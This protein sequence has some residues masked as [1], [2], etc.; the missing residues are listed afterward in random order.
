MAKRLLLIS[1]LVVLFTASVIQA[2]TPLAGPIRAAANKRYFVDAN[3]S[4]FFWLGDT[5]W[6]LFT[7]YTTSDVQTYLDDR[8]AKGFTV[9]Q[10]VLCWWK[11]SG[12]GC[13][14]NTANQNPFL[15]DNPATPN[16]AYFANVDAIVDAAN[17]RG[18]AVAMLPV[19]SHAFISGAATGGSTM[20]N[21]SNARAY[22]RYLGNRYKG[23]S[24]IIWLLGGD[25]PV[26]D[27]AAVYQE[28]AAGIREFDTQVK[29]I[30][31][32][33]ASTNVWPNWSI[34]ATSVQ[35]MNPYP[36]PETSLDFH[37]AESYKWLDK[38]PLLVQ[39]MYTS[40]PSKPVVLG[41][42]S[43]EG[44]WVDTSCC[45]SYPPVNSAWAVRKQAYWSYLGGGSYTYGH[46]AIWS[47]GEWP[48]ASS[49]QAALSAPGAQA[50]AVVK[51]FFTT[52]SWWQ[53]QP[54]NSIFSSGA[55]SGLW[56]NAAAVH[57]S[58]SSALVYISQAAPFTLDLTKVT[59]GIQ[60]AATWMDPRT[61]A[62]TPG[63]QYNT[64][65]QPFT[66]PAGFEDAVL[67]LEGVAG[68]GDTQPP[69]ISAIQA[70]QIAQTSAVISWRTD[71]P[72]SSIVEY[73]LSTSYNQSASAPVV[74]VSHNVPLS[75]LSAGATYHYRVKSADGA[76]N[77][78][79]SKDNVFTTQAATANSPAAI[80]NL[81]VA[82]VLRNSAKLMWSAPTGAKSYDL[83]YSTVAIT[84]STWS[85]ASQ[86]TGEPVPGTAGTNQ[87]FTLDGLAANTNYF[88]AIKSIGTS[89]NSSALSNVQSFTTKKVN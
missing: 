68:S 35:A 13:R 1:V 21:T 55:G 67:I 20:I 53:F 69:A 32:H 6:Q 31:Y 29:L 70:G 51:A 7:S 89:G 74:D 73:G 46:D 61:G 71:E 28:L 24:N 26:F 11:T 54:D 38:I 72:A 12:P 49:W 57:S 45:S 8:Q 5:P 43:Y 4:P 86:V 87:S 58:G 40:S 37:M 25:T 33:P 65:S 18:I 76:G 39:H 30:G 16:D 44:G 79:V 52:K 42:G 85:A 19:W 15:N 34:G 62:Q 75:G 23:K 50:M 3:G 64:G 77:M 22:G 47:H 36:M 84:E 88:V 63:G 9:V 60:V 14:N 80:T 48:A 17:A 41:E 59:Q 10:A 66:L 82:Q 78:A 81:S 2:S 56:Q 83:R 27:K